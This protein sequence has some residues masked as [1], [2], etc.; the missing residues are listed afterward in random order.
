MPEN[1]R[2]TKNVGIQFGHCP[3]VVGG[4]SAE[5]GQRTSARATKDT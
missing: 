2:D 3:V 4:F 1:G 5:A